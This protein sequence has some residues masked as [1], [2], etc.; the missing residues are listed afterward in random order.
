[1]MR[2]GMRTAF[3]LAGW[4]VLLNLHYAQAQN[5]VTIVNAASFRSEQPVTAGSWVSG[6]GV[7]ANVGEVFNTQL[8]LPKALGGV[9][10]TVNGVEAPL[11]YVSGLQ[12]NFVIPYGTQPGIHPVV[13]NGPGGTNNSTVRVINAAPGIFTI[14]AAT[15]PQGAVLNQ[16]NSL[17][18]ENRPAIRGQVIQIFATGH[19][20]LNQQI[21]DG[22]PAPVPA[23][24][25]VVSPKVFIGGVECVVE[26]SGLA[27]EFA[28]LWQINARIPQLAFLSGRLPVQV[29]MNGVDS[30]EVSI[31][32][33]Q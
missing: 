21:E 22:D 2:I 7:F 29:F 4:L 30:N 17:N 11:N 5:T 16:D 27:P 1:M 33:A 12:I 26:F 8:P 3:L 20:A 10:V 15:P 32:V 24:E 31:Y 19:G 13:V 28:A 18:G 9:T 25:T 23:A 14:D 6:F